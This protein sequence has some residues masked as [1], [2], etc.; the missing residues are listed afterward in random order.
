MASYRAIQSFDHI[1]SQMS[2]GY[3]IMSSSN[4]YLYVS[5]SEGDD[6]V[7]DMLEIFFNY[8]LALAKDF[9]NHRPMRSHRMFA[10]L[11]RS[12]WSLIDHS[13]PLCILHH[14]QNIP[15]KDQRTK[16]GREPKYRFMYIR[17]HDDL[18]S[19]DHLHNFH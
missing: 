14:I 2:Y 18:R 12:D 3:E 7:D 13:Q 17:Y 16:L 15:C 10:L 6:F 8:H 19:K 11:F 5:R 4:T 1:I 9:Q